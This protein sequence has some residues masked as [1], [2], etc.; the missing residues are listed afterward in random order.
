MATGLLVAVGLLAEWLGGPRPATAAQFKRCSPVVAHAPGG[1]FDRAAVLVVSGKQDCEKSRR[2]I[3]GA[4]SSSRYNDRV[5]GGW[6]CFST[7]RA[8][9]GH[10]YGASCVRES[11]EREAVRSTTPRPCHSCSKVRD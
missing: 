8:G 1:G 10:L 4:L 6:T 7:A 3:S 5:I 11:E 2:A 9:S